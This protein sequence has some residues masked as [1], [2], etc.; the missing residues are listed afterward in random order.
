MAETYYFGMA[1]P[2]ELTLKFRLNND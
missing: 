1:H 2:W